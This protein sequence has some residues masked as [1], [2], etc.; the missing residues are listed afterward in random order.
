[1]RPRVLVPLATVAALA[2][3]GSALGQGPDGGVVF[4]EEGQASYY[5]EG[6]DGRPTASGEPFDRDALTAAHP[7]LPL[8]AAVTVTDPAT[9]KRVEVE[10]NDR[11]PYADGRAIDL[12]QGAAE[13]LGITREGVAAVRIEATK[14]QVEQ[15]IDRP[16]EV[17]EVERQL[18]GARRAAAAD[19]TPQP[20][21]APS[22]RQP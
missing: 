9:G 6:F 7:E 11:G 22:L 8:G 15:A 5:G 1:M 19:G 10:V 14:P 17:P 4:K 12:S 13:Q 2:S 3:G 18:E 16:G 20:K 21:P